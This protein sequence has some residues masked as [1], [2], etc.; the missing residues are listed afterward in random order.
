MLIKIGGGL[1][2]VFSILL[3]YVKHGGC[4]LVL[5]FINEKYNVFWF[6]LVFG[7]IVLG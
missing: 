3:K 4:R 7:S 2:V 1:V 6:L 5:L